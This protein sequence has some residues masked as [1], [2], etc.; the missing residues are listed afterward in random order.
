MPV[1]VFSSMMLA[2][3]R[4]YI[5]MRLIRFEGQYGVNI[6][7]VSQALVQLIS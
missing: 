1:V 3:V 2:A 6:G 7:L 5:S 4:I